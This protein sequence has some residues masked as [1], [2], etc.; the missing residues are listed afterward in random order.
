MNDIVKINYTVPAGKRILVTSDIHGHLNFLKNVLKSADFCENDLLVIIGDVIEKGPESLKTLRY[1]MELCKK[2]NVIVLAGNV[3]LWR[4]QMIEDINESN[5][6]S[7][8]QYLLS[9]R[10]WKGSSLF[11]DM[12][13][14]CGLEVS[15]AAAVTAA[16]STVLSHFKA[17]LDFLRSRPIILE[18][19]SCVFVHGGLPR[20]SLDDTEGLNKWNFL[21]YDNFMETNLRFEKYV[22]VGHWPVTLYGEKI[23]QSEPVI[24]TEK[25]IISID[26]GCGLKPDGQLNLIVIPDI[27]CDISEIKKYH[28]D[29][30]PR[31]V[32]L[33]SQN[34]SDDSIHIKWTNNEIK[35]IETKDDFTYVQHIQTGKKLWIHND[36]I[37]LE[38]RSNDYT[39]YVLPV[40][41]G[42]IISVVKPTSRGYIA[43]K[44]GVTGWYY[45]KIEKV[46]EL[47]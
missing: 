35:E 34:A 15:S 21:K 10:K 24:D 5:S 37:Y 8:Y 39:D 32:A 36:Y 23:A 44:D 28:Y 12:A 42:D 31:Y 30:F 11:D 40:E 14:E 26:G 17:E 22:V 27:S 47:I 29:E 19:Q 13:S 16:K 6:E 2:G 7:F 20:A 41:K 43:K 33:D 18:T 3:D 45:G 25:K 4:V 46:R 1:V 9:Q 38:H